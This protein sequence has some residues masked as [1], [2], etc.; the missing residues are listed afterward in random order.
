MDHK[1][2]QQFAR[3]WYA[4]WNAH[5]LERILN[6]YADE[7]EMASPLV[8]L[9]TG[10]AD[11]RIVGKEALRAYF[12]AGLEKYPSLRFEPLE[13]FVEV[14]SLVLH[15]VSANGQAAAEVVFLD[16]DGKIARYLAHYADSER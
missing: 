2:A 10:E 5:D 8:S 1:A 3:E 4:A 14:N 11:G 12:T 7:V 9:L 16:E 15:Y 13:L 6:H